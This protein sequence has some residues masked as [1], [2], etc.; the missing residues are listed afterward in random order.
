MEFSESDCLEALIRASNQLGR[1]P[2]MDEYDS[3]NL[4]PSASTISDHCGTWQLAIAKAG[5]NRES[6]REYTEE[7]CINALK[8]AADILGS[9]PSLSEYRKLSLRPSASTIQDRYGS[10]S[11]AKK[12]AGVEDYGEQSPEEE[13]R[14]FFDKFG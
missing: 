4:S 1:T 10:W 6:R 2:T 9:E 7:N 8:N 3:M 5:L 11:E 12:A 13:A 14:E